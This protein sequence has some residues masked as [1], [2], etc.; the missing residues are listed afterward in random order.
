MKYSIKTV[1]YL[2]FGI[3]YS[4]GKNMILLDLNVML[5]FENLFNVL[6]S[7]RMTTE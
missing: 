1:W 5:L 4:Y 3:Q 6:L 7:K 2:C